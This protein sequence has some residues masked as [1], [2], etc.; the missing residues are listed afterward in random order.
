MKAGLFSYRWLR[1]LLDRPRA[2]LWI[3]GLSATLLAASL[4][5][6][7][8]A[9]DY[10]H[11]LAMSPPGEL[12]GFARAPLD[13]YRFATRE[14]VP[15]WMQQ[16]VLTWWDDPDARLAFWRPLSALT[17][18]L[19]HLLWRLNGPL[20]HLHSLLW[21]LLVFA[22]VRALYRRLLPG[23]AWVASLAL[24][25]YALDDSR[26]WFCSFVAA[27]NAAVATAVSV[28]A[29]VFH[30]RHRAEGWKPGR[31]LGPLVLALSLLCGE[32]SVAVC[33]YLLTYALFLD[34]GPPGRRLM[35]LVPHALVVV[36]W[37]AVYRALGYGVTGSGLYIEPLQEPGRFALAFLQ[38]API[39][40]FAQ[41][42]GFWSDLWSALFLFPRFARLV[43]ASALLS[44][45]A[46]GWL[47]FPL[48]R[49]DALLRFSLTGSLLAVIP[50]SATFTSDRML[51]W[52][53][54]GASL[55]LA[56]FLALYAEDRPALGP[57]A[58][59]GGA[60]PG[61]GAG[62][63]QRYPGAAAARPSRARHHELA[64]DTRARRRG[65]TERTFHREQGGG[66]GQPAR[67]SHGLVRPRRT[68]GQGRAPAQGAA[69]ARHL[70]HRA[71]A[72]TAGRED[73]PGQAARRL[74]DQPGRYAAAQPEQTPEA[75]TGD[76]SRRREDPRRENDP[77]RTAARG[78]SGAFLPPARR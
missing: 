24:F 13:I 35:S 26:S 42:S 5:T 69:L 62:P 32:G 17:H 48:L 59:P 7:L 73:A 4:D 51:S 60:G 57:R 33:G 31:W 9:D 14:S 46:L 77:G 10:V 65:H 38:R 23:A 29:L 37:W 3:V 6:G 41:W 25:F 21:A 27:R 75:R 74:P 16:G 53:G 66:P 39:L 50:A 47:L 18:Y 67:R 78:N 52:V 63:R 44:L 15:L 12:R 11:E 40:L 49:R 55:A 8:I 58:F 61:A 1:R 43:M 72:G 19:D 68:R 70:H 45:L 20:M 76:R 71:R 64:R 56:R 30:V 36:V 22:G 2:D 34:R 28:W 54:I